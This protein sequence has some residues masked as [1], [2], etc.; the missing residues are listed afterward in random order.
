MNFD[1]YIYICFQVFI[2]FTILVGE[3]VI[4]FV[5]VCLAISIVSNK[6]NTLLI[7]NDDN[8]KTTTTK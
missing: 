8:T 4:T 6:I 1:L 5:N 7:A 2:I 3:N